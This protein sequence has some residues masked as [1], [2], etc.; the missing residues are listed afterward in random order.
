MHD[1]MPPRTTISRI[2]IGLLATA[3]LAAGG[4]PAAAAERAVLILDASGSMWGQLEGRAKIDIAR[5]VVRDLMDRWSPEVELGLMAYGHRR[6]GD[7]DDIELLIPPGPGTGP[8]VLGAVDSLQPRGKTPI[9][10]ALRQA[11]AALRAAEDR[12]TVILVSDGEE[13]C[14]GDP[15]AAAAELEATGVDL[16]VHV[17]GF[18]VS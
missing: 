2:L 4:G 1:R 8:A 13:T 14:G 16:T 15:C 12:A 5:E 18:D 10:E 9:T 3:A 6:K 11:A 17:V 7:C